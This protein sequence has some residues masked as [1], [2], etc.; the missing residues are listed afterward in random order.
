[1]FD[2]TD[3]MTKLDGYEEQVINI[4]KEA[5]EDCQSVFFGRTL[6]PPSIMDMFSAFNGPEPP[7]LNKCIMVHEENWATSSLSE[8]LSEM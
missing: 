3:E 7:R 6:P 8:S 4:C 1:M 2:S 5:Q